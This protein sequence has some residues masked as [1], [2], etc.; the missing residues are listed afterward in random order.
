MPAI[1]ARPITSKQVLEHSK[2]AGLFRT[3]LQ[4]VPA[5]C[6]FLYVGFIAFVT[7]HLLTSDQILKGGFDFI[8]KPSLGLF[9]MVSCIVLFWLF[10]DTMRQQW[11]ADKYKKEISGEKLGRL[12]E[13]DEILK[14]IDVLRQGL[15]CINRMLKNDS[16]HATALAYLRNA[17]DVIRMELVHQKGRYSILRQQFLS[18]LERKYPGEILPP[19]LQK[20][21]V[22]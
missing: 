4:I 7:W 8:M 18:S 17:R 16:L 12:T 1:V 22:A 3:F 6:S 14:D 15:R 13:I 20:K 11:L 19:V 9:S 5:I 10:F 2:K 21:K